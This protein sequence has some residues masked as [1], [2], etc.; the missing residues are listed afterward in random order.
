MRFILGAPCCQRGV[1]DRGPQPAPG[2][3]R[4]GVYEHELGLRVFAVARPHAAESPGPPDPGPVWRRGRQCHGKR[5]GST[6]VSTSSR[7]WPKRSAQS[8]ARRRMH[9]DSTREP[10]FFGAPGR[11]RKR[12]LLV[13]RCSRPNR[14]PY[15][16]PIH[17]SRAPHLSAAAENSTS[18]SQRPRWCAA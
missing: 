3:A 2:G 5:A 8:R 4:Q 16:Q 13:I 10:R 12:E 9:S 17:R 6:N 11:I 14:M 15:S 1:E 7:P 18:A